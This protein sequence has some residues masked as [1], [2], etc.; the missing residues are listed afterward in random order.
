MR[1][2]RLVPQAQGCG[3]DWG[4]RAADVLTRPWLKDVRCF[5]GARNLKGFL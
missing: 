4:R 2:V 5:H 1:G 3:M